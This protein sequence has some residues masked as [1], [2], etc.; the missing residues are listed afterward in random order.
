M[1]Y[2]YPGAST[3]CAVEVTLPIKAI[4]AGTAGAGVPPVNFL[5]SGWFRLT[6]WFTDDTLLGFG[7]TAGRFSVSTTTTNMNVIYRVS[8]SASNNQFRVNSAFTGTAQWQHITWF[9]SI[10]NANMTVANSVVWI[11]TPDT[12]PTEYSLTSV[13][14]TGGQTPVLNTTTQIG[15]ANSG[16]FG[17]STQSIVGDVANVT[18]ISS[19]DTTAGLNFFGIAPGTALTSQ[20]KER[21]LSTIVYPLWRGDYGMAIHP[22]QRQV[23][24]TST[25]PS[26]AASP[27]GFLLHM[28][29]DGSTQAVGLHGT[30]L[31][32]FA[33]AISSGT[34]ATN[35]APSTTQD[36]P[37][38]SPTDL[39]PSVPNR[40]GRRMR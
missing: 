38:R 28:P 18:Y 21:L 35:P 4:G 14:A 32:G 2:N 19:G 7:D 40:T 11:G 17:S 31:N 8:P 15:A 29:L 22:D 16:T 39:Y 24:I 26:G 34:G 30:T 1:A 27:E 33:S 36:N 6:R 12:P 23:P 3:G 20:I 5:V 37:R 9:L 10:T 13:S 25:S